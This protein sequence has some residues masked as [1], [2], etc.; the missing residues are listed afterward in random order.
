MLNSAHRIVGLYFEKR[1]QDCQR[2]NFGDIIFDSGKGVD[3]Y[4]T[5]QGSKEGS[6]SGVRLL[7][8]I[9]LICLAGCHCH[10]TAL[11]QPC[12][13]SQGCRVVTV[14]VPAAAV[15]IDSEGLPIHTVLL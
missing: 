6:R 5:M 3:S 7:N 4:V 10:I 1:K 15:R 2:P 14:H 9:Q 8:S 12:L 11:C 13:S